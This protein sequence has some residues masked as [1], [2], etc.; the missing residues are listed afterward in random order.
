MLCPHVFG[1]IS[2][3][4]REISRVFVNFVDLLEIHGSAIARNIRSPVNNS[5]NIILFNS[6][7][8]QKSLLE[9]KKD[10]GESIQKTTTKRTPY[11]RVILNGVIF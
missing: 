10:I 1:K 3:E 8:F 4:F 6:K 11:V 7:K 9:G 2:S 5:V